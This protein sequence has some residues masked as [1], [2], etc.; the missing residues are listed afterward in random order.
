MLVLGL[1]FGTALGQINVN[2]TGLH[3]A[4][5]VFGID[6]SAY[7]DPW[8]NN[9]T[10]TVFGQG[11]TTDPHLYTDV[12]FGIYGIG[13]APALTNTNWIDAN[14]VG[15]F[16]SISDGFASAMVQTYGIW[17]M[18]DVANSSTVTVAATG[19]IAHSSSESSFANANARTYGISAHGALVNSGSLFVT[20][21]GGTAESNGNTPFY[22]G[23]LA[24]AEVFGIYGHSEVNNT[25]GIT[26]L[27]T[28]GTATSAGGSA[29]AYAYA[30]GIYGM[31]EQVTNSGDI[32]VTA[33]GGTANV[34]EGNADAY[35][36]GILALGNVANSG[37]ITAT[38]T[39]GPGFTTE[40][41]GIFMSQGEGGIPSTLTN[42]G[43]IRAFGNTAYELYVA[44]GT[45]TLVNVY[46]VTL[47]GNPQDPSIFVNDGA[48]LA[49]NSA[50]LTVT[51]VPGDTLWNTEYRLFGVGEQGSVGGNFG[52]V[53]AVNPDVTARYYT[54]GTANAADD[55]VAL[56]YAPEA[57]E[58]LASVT[59]EKQMIGRASSA[60]NEHMTTALLYD[61]LSPDESDEESDPNS[62]GE[63]ALGRTPCQRAG[64]VFVEPHYSYFKKNKDPLGYDAGAWGLSAGYTQCVTDSLLGVHIG[65]GQSDI[66]YTG[67]GYSS[68]SE[69][70]DIATSG[71]N[72]LTRWQS[73]V[74]RYGFTGFHAWHEY[75][76]LT[77]LSLNQHETASYTSYGGT[78]L[79]MV[80][81][82]LRYRKHV[83]FPEIGADWL[84]VHR[85]SYTSEATDAGWD[86]RYS[87]MD[88]HDVAGELALHW[89][90][91]Y[92]YKKLLIEPSA[93]IAIHQ[94][95]TD[96]DTETVQSIEGA[97]PVLVKAEQDRTSVALAA[98]LML[99][100][101]RS[102]F[103][104]A[105]DGQFAR[106]VQEHNFWAKFR[107][108][109]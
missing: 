14:G 50:A 68:N 38:A 6:G 69:V 36:Y 32:A 83:F 97:D 66:D 84:W 8:T 98:A 109:F 93:S 25:G 17:G 55:T 58:A 15:G 9:Q 78:A 33:A 96:G 75:D 21:T 95:L 70:Q 34:Q 88:D 89:L 82:T 45:T 104:L 76:G 28:G 26:A 86:T 107:W 44:Y 52:S 105:Y 73:W 103:S 22:S 67:T 10:I 79:L 19:G 49:L 29:N 62:A 94:L 43:T 101:S 13:S 5:Q 100:W 106:D 35:A 11:D 51:D 23:A 39:A 71:M 102:T 77:G 24:E 81:R 4:N 53:Q 1:L 42:T 31:F 37:D 3:D 41:Y 63:A 46:N 57:S 65:Y 54:G 27:A 30:Y 108:R 91:R 90:S 72:G 61:A 18:A 74:F 7:V 99:R 80:G 56:A 60:I 85:R 92:R 12:S 2:R 20:A 48:T 47:D 87:T 40:A 59:A 64:G 16:T